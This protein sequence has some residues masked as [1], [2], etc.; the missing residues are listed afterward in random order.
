MSSQIKQCNCKKETDKEKRDRIAQI[1]DEY[2]GKEGSLI[3]ILHMAQG[4]Y[5]YLPLDL[6][7]FIAE[8]LGK[9]LSEVY[10]VATFYSFF[11]VNPRGENTIRVKNIRYDGR[12]FP[13]RKKLRHN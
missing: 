4:I 3:Q 10:G 11:S 13:G 6:Q 5:G 2:K 1:I 12:N 7:Q 8:K 9:P